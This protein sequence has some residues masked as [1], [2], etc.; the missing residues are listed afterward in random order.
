MT[1]IYMHRFIQKTLANSNRKSKDNK[2][3]EMYI[4]IQLSFDFFL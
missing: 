4:Y 3:Q 1:F 2:I